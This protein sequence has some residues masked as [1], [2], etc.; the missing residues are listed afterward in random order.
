MPVGSNIP[1]QLAPWTA[2]FTSKPKVCL[3]SGRN[4]Q[5]IFRWVPEIIRRPG[6][7]LQVAML[8]LIKEEIYQESVWTDWLKII[9]GT[10][11]KDVQCD[12]ELRQCYMDH[13]LTIPP[14]SVYDE[15]ASAHTSRR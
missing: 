6:V 15:Q 14:R 7:L 10:V 13:V 9:A 2:N 4:F 1:N 11:H 5:R 3:L 8:W 12:D